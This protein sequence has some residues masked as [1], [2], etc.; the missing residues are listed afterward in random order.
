MKPTPANRDD[1]ERYMHQLMRYVY[2]LSGKVSRT[3]AHFPRHRTHS[4]HWTAVKGAKVEQ[5]AMWVDVFDCFTEC[6]N[7]ELFY[8]AAPR[9]GLL[10]PM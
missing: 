8:F 2:Y 9:N 3:I 10:D 6:S 7:L 1:V 5:K 4:L